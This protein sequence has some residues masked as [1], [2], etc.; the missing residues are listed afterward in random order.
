[1]D[2]IHQPDKQG[3]IPSIHN[4]C[5][6]RC[7]RCRFVRQCRVGIMDVDD[8]DDERTEVAD[9]RVE[10]YAARLRKVMGLPPPDAEEKEE[11]DDEEEDGWDFDLEAIEP[12]PELEARQTAV[13]KA[14]QEHPFTALS[15]GYGDKVSEWIGPREERLRHMGVTLHH[16]AA[17]GISPALRTPQVLLLSEA[18]EEVLWF[19]HMLYVKGQRA[20]TGKLEDTQDE[21]E[22]GFDPLQSDWNGTAKLVLHI[23]DRSIA[24]WN[25]IAERWSSEAASVQPMITDL[26]ACEALIRADFPDAQKFIRPGFDAP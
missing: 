19:Q 18:V 6:R 10:D 17:L 13:R 9:E 4:Y 8:V 22:Q 25:M 16:R 11:D 15:L 12:D 5:D 24:S 23:I 3:F 21:V 2:N 20:L 14:V 26:R 7:E 1:M